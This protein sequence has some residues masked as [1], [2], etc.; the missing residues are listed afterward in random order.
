MDANLFMG[1]ATS[2]DN[3]DDNNCGVKY[4]KDKDKLIKKWHKLVKMNLHLHLKVDE[5]ELLYIS[6]RIITCNSK[7]NRCKNRYR[8]QLRDS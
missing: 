4:G 8:Y 5:K 2:G 1:G 3:C 7:N 6:N